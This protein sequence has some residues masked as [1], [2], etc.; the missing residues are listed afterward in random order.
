MSGLSGPWDLFRRSPA[1]QSGV[2]CVSGP[3]T[4]SSRPG[5]PDPCD[6]DAAV[7][8]P[9]C[10]LRA[11]LQ[12]PT[13]SAKRKRGACFATPISPPP[14]L[15]PSPTADS[16]LSTPRPVSPPAVDCVHITFV[17]VRL[18]TYPALVCVSALSFSHSS[19]S[20]RPHSRK[21]PGPPRLP[22]TSLASFPS[23]LPPSHSPLVQQSNAC[24]DTHPTRTSFTT[25]SRSSN[26]LIL[27]HH[28]QPPRS[29][30]ATTCTASKQRTAPLPPN[31]P[32]F[33]PATGTLGTHTWKTR[34]SVH[35]SAGD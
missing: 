1:Y 22:V 2:S 30:R 25:P 21:L 24:S 28:T 14:P 33:S 35:F 23:L 5:G 15:T 12:H 3:C 31:P 29:D 7:S 20:T 34:A 6:S 13:T 27:H 17:T 10:A 26:R 19:T 11:C 4:V 32:L 16:A 9:A 18:T 8:L